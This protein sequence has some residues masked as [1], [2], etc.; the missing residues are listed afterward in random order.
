[1]NKPRNNIVIRK[2]ISADTD[3]L[4]ELFKDAVAAINIRRYTQ[5]QVQ[6]WTK[7][8]SDEW[9]ASL[10]N[11][12]AY[13]AEIN[14]VIV[15]FADLRRDGYLDRLYIHKDY[16]GRFIALHLLRAIEKAAREI[17]LK[18]IF[19]DCSITAKIPAERAGFRVIKEQ[20]VSKDG[21]D[22][23]NYVM[24]KEINA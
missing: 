19:T 22:F 9:Q 2:F 4:I 14:G 1:M 17:G 13:V 10:Q 6:T 21:V 12:L 11:N 8:N 15:G 16:Q 7:V 23:I 20:T 24:E 5:E 18:K 3:K